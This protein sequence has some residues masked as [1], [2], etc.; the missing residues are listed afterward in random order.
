MSFLKVFLGFVLNIISSAPAVFS[1]HVRH[2]FFFRE[3]GA[4]LSSKEFECNVRTDPLLE[5]V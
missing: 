5:E 4:S 1:S 2:V 3:K